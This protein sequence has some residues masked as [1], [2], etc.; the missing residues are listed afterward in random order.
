[1]QNEA[2]KK[3]KTSKQIKIE[4]PPR[5]TVSKDEALKRMKQFAQRNGAVPCHCSTEQELRSICLTFR[6][7]SI[8]TY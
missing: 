4:R 2:M 5:A 7:P 8:K 3:P 1:M 6:H